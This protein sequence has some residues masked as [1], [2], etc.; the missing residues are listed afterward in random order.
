MTFP[1]VLLLIPALCQNGT[2]EADSLSV[3][4]SANVL[5]QAVATACL[6]AES[7]DL[8][9]KDRLGAT[10]SVADAIRSFAG[11][12]IK[13]FGGIGGLKTVN[14]RSLG[15]E[16]AGVFID[17]LQV[18]NAQNMQVDLG[19][20]STDD[21]DAI[22]LYNGQRNARLQSAREYSAG[23]AIYLFTAA[24]EVSADNPQNVKIRLRGGSFGTLSPYVR[25]ER[26]LN[27]KDSFRMSFEY[28]S[29]DGRYHFRK[30]DTT[31]VRRN[32]DLQS[33]RA[34]GSIFHKGQSTWNVKAYWYDSERG[35]PGPVVRR[36]QNTTEDRQ[37][38]RYF[39]VQG[40]LS[41]KMPDIGSW[42]S[43]GAASAKYSFSYTRYRTDP[44]KDPSAMPIDNGYWQ[45]NAYISGSWLASKG[46]FSIGLAQDAEYSHLHADLQDFVCPSRYSSWTAATF[47]IAGNNYGVSAILLYSL[48]ADRYKENR[49]GF[50]KESDTRDFFTPA[51]TARYSLDRH[52]TF[53]FLAKHSCRM[54]SF[55]DLYYT[56]VGNA[57][58]EPEKAIQLSLGAKRQDEFHGISSEARAESY[59]NSVSDKI[60]AVPTSNQFRWSMYNIGETR[61]IGIDAKWR[62][63]GGSRLQWGLLAKYSFQR[64]MDFSDKGSLTWKGQIPYIPKHSGSI[65]GNIEYSGWRAEAVW[66]MTGRR[67]SSSANLPD[68]R[69]GRW[70]TLDLHLSKTL[71]KFAIRLNVNNLLDQHYE[72][73]PNYPMPGASIIASAEYSF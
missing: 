38:D 45:Q 54:P 6:S 73:V 71:G 52:W 7:T 10:A 31:M 59:F 24:P 60:I 17:G 40:R 66:V 56:L 44:A 69:I 50:R 4:D 42:Q 67:W 26:R 39:F 29:T 18:E 14:V 62:L 65:S 28:L 25:F 72:V 68:Y 41:G 21:L 3:R 64:A 70:Q 20:F 5:R 63:Q 34:E 15:S 32:S 8:I 9:T 12:Q 16:H 30:F 43:E 35:L 47:N 53:S 37:T 58:L 48:V 23:N 2:Q 11:I 57:S 51:L 61:I 55:N 13:D 22:A 49:G 1:A 36:A 46:L 27:S 19:R 33:F